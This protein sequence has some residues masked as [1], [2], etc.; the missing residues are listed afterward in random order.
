[1]TA[2]PPTRTGVTLIELLVVITILGTMAGMA[3]V[4]IAGGPRAQPSSA[5]ADIA[6]ARRRAVDTRRPVPVAAMDQGTRI[7][8][9]ALPDG[10]VLGRRDADHARRTG[11]S[12]APR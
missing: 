9:L 4:A 12:H 7:V 6:A 3:T 8:L 1:M 10:R 5:G 11:R 2:S